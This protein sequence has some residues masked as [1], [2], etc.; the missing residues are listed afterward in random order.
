MPL[1]TA[2]Y[3]GAM[4]YWHHLRVWAERTNTVPFF[5]FSYCDIVHSNVIV[6]TSLAPLSKCYSGVGVL[7]SETE[8]NML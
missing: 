1:V 2:H 8:C 4:L 7:P 3:A 6:R 5:P